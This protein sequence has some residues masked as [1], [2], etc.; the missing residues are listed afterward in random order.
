MGEAQPGN[1]PVVPDQSSDR[2]LHR[3]PSLEP[4]RISIDAYALSTFS[5]LDLAE[6]W[7]W[8]DKEVCRYRAFATKLYPSE[9]AARAAVSRYT[10]TWAEAVFNGRR[11]VAGRVRRDGWDGTFPSFQIRHVA[12]SFEGRDYRISGCGLEGAY[13]QLAYGF[14]TEAAWRVVRAHREQHKIYGALLPGDTPK[15]ALFVFADSRGDLIDTKV[16]S[17]RGCLPG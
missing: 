4:Q 3:D 7:M 8:C 16:A 12:G 17:V 9:A 1:S 14:G 5:S 15:G 6:G 10:E 13:K 11:S 2:Q